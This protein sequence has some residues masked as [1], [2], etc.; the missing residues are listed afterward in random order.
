[1]SK[2]QHKNTLNNSQIKMAPSKPRNPDT[3]SPGYSN[4]TKTKEVYRKYNLMKIIEAFKE[5]NTMEQ[6]RDM[7][8]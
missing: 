4:K 2:G 5:E 3:G 1:M 8:K 6:V 7:I